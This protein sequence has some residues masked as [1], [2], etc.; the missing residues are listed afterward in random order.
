MRSILEIPRRP[1]AEIQAYWEP[2]APEWYRHESAA[3]YFIDL[4][5]QALSLHL[6]S[7]PP[8]GRI[9]DVAS[10]ANPFAY[11]PRELRT[12]MHAI[13][14]S[15]TALALNG[16]TKKSLADARNSFPFRDDSFIL[17][18]SIFGMRYF[19][20]QKEVISEMLRVLL[21][22]GRLVII[23]FQGAVNDAAVSTFEA[24]VLKHNPDLKRNAILQSKRIFPGN[25]HESPMD[26][27]TGIKL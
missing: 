27:L 18:T 7:L 22:G 8:D 10:G 23:D 21:S 20:N 14:V 6:L 17:V 19:E 1:V 15:N 26:V 9:L 4:V 12:R 25:P 3:I 11:F 16:I 24:E 2:R 13:D 5:K